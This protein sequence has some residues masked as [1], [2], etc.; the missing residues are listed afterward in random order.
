MTAVFTK[1]PEDRLDYD[2][3]FAR[4]R[5]LTPGDTISAILNAEISGGTVE[6][7]DTDF[8]D[9]AVKVWINGGADGDTA[10]VTVEIQT[11]QGREK[12]VTFKVRVREG[13]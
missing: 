9:T 10:T 4:Q 6:I 1:R 11:V 2:I 8:T 12:E 5:W 13:C 7:D 3:D